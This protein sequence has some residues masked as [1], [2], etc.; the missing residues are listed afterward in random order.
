MFYVKPVLLGQAIDKAY[1]VLYEQNN[2]IVD[3]AYVELCLIVYGLI[4][5]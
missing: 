1:K 2:R 4:Q 3:R 5:L